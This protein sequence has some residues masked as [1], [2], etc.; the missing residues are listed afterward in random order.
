[1]RK[2]IFTLSIAALM[3]SCNND[4]SVK[5]DA[6]IEVRDGNTRSKLSAESE[7][8]EELQ[9]KAAERQ[10]E[11]EEQEKKKM[12]NLTTMDITPKVFDFGNIPKGAPTTTYF[13]IKN[14]GDKP[15]IINETKA[16]CGCTV[17]EKPEEPIMPGEDYKLEVTF[18]SN[19]SQAGTSINKTITV[20]GNIPETNQVVNIKGN[21]S[22]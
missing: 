17:P 20:S 1:M 9:A 16:S 10:K 8:A 5:T 22:K 2:I 11:R 13:T 14:T 18:T 21:V 3:F 7:N 19:P 6:N 4:D 12:E 15:L